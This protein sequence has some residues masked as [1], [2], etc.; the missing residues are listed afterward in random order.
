M[1]MK[2][3]VSRRKFLKTGL[4]AAA[5]V[6]F[7]TIVP[8]SVLGEY[9]PSK[10]I[11]IGAIGVGRISRVHDMPGILP[12]ENAKIMAVCDLDKHRLEDGKK[13]VNDFYSKKTGKDYDGVTMYSSHRELLAN[14][15]IDAVVISTPDHQHALLGVHAVQAGKHVYLQKPASLTIAEGRALSNAV[16]ASGRILQ[17]GSQQRSTVQFRYAAELV[18]NGRIGEIQRVEIGLP[19]DPP[20]GDKTPMPVPE[21]FSYD[22]WL[23]E[24]PYQYYTVDRVHPQT[25][26]DRPGWLRMRQFGA[27][28]ITGWGAHHVDSAHWGMNTEYTGPIEVWGEAKFPDHGLWDVHGDFQTEALYANGTRMSISGS[29]PNG[30]KFY[31][32]KGWI[33]VSRG[34]EQVTKS[35]PA[36]KLADNTALASSDPKII[37]SVIGPDEIH[38]YE[39]KEQHGNWLEC[40]ISG[41]APISPVELG[42]R[43]CSTCLIHDIV[44][45]LKRKVYWDPVAERF[46]NDDE[47]N[48]LL[49]RPQRA[50]YRLSWPQVT[51]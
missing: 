29:Y 41:K 13:F 32:T 7:P 15:D 49:T 39:S 45:V 46:R 25:G 9:A 2:T 43:A 14:K 30:I 37:K 28:M 10:R 24:T 44:M 50:P 34:N 47:A 5:V 17:I 35:D 21:W 42:H 27:G 19:G 16:Q 1:T 8:S 18:R 48:S 4:G 40:I 12:Y 51:E 3:G 38:L 11:N 36:A 33:F 26:Y 22:E 20:G 6:G 23:G 31:G